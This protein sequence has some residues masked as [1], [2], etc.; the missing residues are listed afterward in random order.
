MLKIT[1]AAVFFT[2]IGARAETLISD[3][4]RFFPVLVQV[5]ESDGTP[6]HDAEVRLADFRSKPN[7]SEPTTEKFVKA[8]ELP[9]RTDER[10]CAI[11]WFF[12]RFGHTY[13]DGKK[14]KYS[15][16]LDGTLVVRRG[17]KEVYRKML[18]LWAPN[19]G[20]KPQENDAPWVQVTI[21]QEDQGEAEQDAAMKEPPPTRPHP[22]PE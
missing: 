11:V 20:Y 5:L 18:G 17:D 14:V 8:L 16:S 12:G 19:A 4:S 6:V 10:G 15:Q 13:V 2:L 3:G 1:I 21:E 9:V 22:E 7:K